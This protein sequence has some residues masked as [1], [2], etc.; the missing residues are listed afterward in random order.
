MAATGVDLGIFTETKITDGV[1][2]QFSSGYN[3]TASN[4]ISA[5][6][7]GIALFWRD[8]RG[9]GDARPQCSDFRV[10]EGSEAVFCRGSVHPT[11]RSWHHVNPHSASMVR[12][13]ERVRTTDHGDLNA[14][15]INPRDERE[16]G[17]AEQVYA[18]DLVDMGRHFRQHRRRRCRGRWTWRMR[19]GRRRYLPS[20]TI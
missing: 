7:G 18:M 17:I 20:V 16:D 2:T 5:C 1:Y 12:V 10:S 13:P 19:R 3:V 4:A 15:L 9:S 8:N 14:N 6:Q 11:L